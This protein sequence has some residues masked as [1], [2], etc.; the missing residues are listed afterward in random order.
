MEITKAS[1]IE[2]SPYSPQKK[3]LTISRVFCSYK[4]R[5][6]E[7]KSSRY[8]APQIMAILKQAEEGVEVPVL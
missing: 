6:F 1:L 4:R 3:V 8:T 2:V 7:M 5:K